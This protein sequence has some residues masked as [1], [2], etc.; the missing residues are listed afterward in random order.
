MMLFVNLSG[1]SSR[2]DAKGNSLRIHGTTHSGPPEWRT[3][4]CQHFLASL[5]L[6]LGLRIIELLVEEDISGVERTDKGVSERLDLLLIEV[7]HYVV[8]E[9]EPVA[10]LFHDWKKTERIR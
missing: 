2:C 6:R 1:M 5:L 9:H 10:G 7:R 3:L 8:V 4:S